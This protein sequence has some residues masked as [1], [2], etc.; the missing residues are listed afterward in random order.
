L[1]G[2]NCGR[3]KEIALGIFAN[4][5]SKRNCLDNFPKYD[6]QLQLIDTVITEIQ[7][8]SDSS[9]LIQAFSVL[10]RVIWYNSEVKPNI[11]WIVTILNL[12]F[13]NATNFL[14]ESSTNVLLLGKIVLTLRSLF[15]T[16]SRTD[17]FGSAETDE[18]D[19]IQLET[20]MTQNYDVFCE[21]PFVPSLC[22]GLN[23]LLKCSFENEADMDD[24]QLPPGHVQVSLCSGLGCLCYLQNFKA[25][26]TVLKRHNFLI[27]TF[28]KEFFGK[29]HLYTETIDIDKTFEYFATGLS[30][31]S[32]CHRGFSKLER[33]CIIKPVQAA[34]R[35][36]TRDELKEGKGHELDLR[37]SVGVVV[38]EHL[39]EIG[40]TFGLTSVYACVNEDKNLTSFLKFVNQAAENFAQKEKSEESVPVENGVGEST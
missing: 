26:Q 39:A 11:T 5:I 6:D 25:G 12:E 3:L 18:P 21:T 27:S 32:F 8:S 15:Q 38:H 37:N 34:S 22:E 35:L 10:E 28:L 14:L 4:V 31:M 1:V 30:L 24:I 33:S 20:M 16:L 9:I 7:A 40:D 17:V 29:F 23:E 13:V 36:T 2:S 19:E